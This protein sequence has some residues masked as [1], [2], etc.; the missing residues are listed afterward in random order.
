MT[1]VFPTGWGLLVGLTDIPQPNAERLAAL[2]RPGPDGRRPGDPRDLL[3]G[4]LWTQHPTFA[5]YFHGDTG[6]GLGA[7]HQTGWTALVA[8]LICTPKSDYDP[9]ESPS[10]H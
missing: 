4:P 1:V 3:S 6:V 7:T 10:D 9:S 8:H 2:A 5:E